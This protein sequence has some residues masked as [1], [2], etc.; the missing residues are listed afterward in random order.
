[1]DRKQ[2]RIL[3]IETIEIRLLDIPRAL[4]ELG[5]DVY[6]ASLNI[7]AQGYEKKASQ[8]VVTTIKDYEIQYAISYDFSES[9]AQ[10]CFETG[11]PYVSWVYD[12]PQKELYTH[13]ALYPC[14]YIFVFDKKQKERLRQIG[15]K[16]VYYMPLAI[17]PNKV[18]LVLERVGKEK[19]FADIAFV[20]QLYKIDN[21]DFIM[22]QAEEKVRRSMEANIEECFLCWDENTNLHGKMEDI[23][24]NYF[25]LIDKGKILK[26]YPYISE[27][28]YYEAAVTSRLIANRERISILNTLAEKY[29]VRL[30]TN[31][32]GTEQL[33]KKVKILPNVKYDEISKV[34]YNSKIN[35]NITLHCI[36]SGAPQ[37][38]FDVMAAGGF[39]ISNYQKEL[40]ELFVVGEEIVLY[41]NL[42]ELEELAEYYLNHEEERIRIA[43]N[44]RKKVLKYH[45]LHD[46]METAIEFIVKKEKNR[47]KSYPVLQ[48]EWVYEKI[49]NLLETGSYQK[50]YDLLHS[51]K[52]TEGVPKLDEIIW[53]QEML[54]CW[55]IELKN[56]TSNI[57]SNTGSMKEAEHKYLSIKH[58]LW[59]IENKLNEEICRETVYRMCESRESKLLIAWIIKTHIQDW[60]RVFIAVSDYMQEYN[61]VDAVKLLSYG[62]MYF[63]QSKKLILKKEKSIKILRD[64]LEEIDNG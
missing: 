13:Y 35:I 27:Q 7:S 20:G 49:D 62:Q 39:M 26:K 43:E 9:I 32:P 45:D 1:M 28:F 48:R 52:Y 54:D 4:D 44:G 5:Y 19:D 42:E 61:I 29:D 22:N 59:R 16:N 57:F 3:Y 15:I 63:P 34:Y 17:M 30:Y 37:R 53:L 56:E 31:Y 6:K 25:S 46:S 12:A 2:I 50:L 51:I 36:E 8:T 60:E 47:K 55:K 21:L 41:H 38:V 10:A 18:E 40:E 14:N 11:I 33:N 24:V 23:C 64:I 58:G